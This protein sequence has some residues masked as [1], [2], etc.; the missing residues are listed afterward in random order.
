MDLFS[1]RIIGWSMGSRITKEL[2]LD[3]LLMAV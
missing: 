2:A 3:A 1:R